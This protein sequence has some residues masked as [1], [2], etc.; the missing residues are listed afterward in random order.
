MRVTVTIMLV[1]LSTKIL[2]AQHVALRISSDFKV[3]EATLRNQTVTHSIYYNDNFYTVTNSGGGVGKWLFTKL[4][5]MKY[6]VTLSRFDRDMK[7]IGK[8]EL[9]NGERDFGPLMPSMICFNN[10]LYLAYFK[11]ADKSSFSLYLARVDEDNLS[12]DTA[13]AL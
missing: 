6:I 2:F 7:E 10:G 5:D 9:D 13:S 4:Y 11:T 3:K 12:L 8:V 1:M